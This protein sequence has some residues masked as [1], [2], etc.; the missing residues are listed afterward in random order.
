MYHFQH[1]DAIDRTF[2]PCSVACS[3]HREYVNFSFWYHSMESCDPIVPS[4]KVL[5]QPSQFAE[6]YGVVM[7]QE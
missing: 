6:Q 7:Q 5:E 4:P 1:V 3:Y 2:S